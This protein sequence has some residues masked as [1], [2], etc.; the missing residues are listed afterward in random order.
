MTLMTMEIN[1]I[2]YV[3]YLTT[4]YTN[5]NVWIIQNSQHFNTDRKIVTITK[6]IC[7]ETFAL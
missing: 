1:F 6:R 3:Q 7:V 5:L 4:K 2:N